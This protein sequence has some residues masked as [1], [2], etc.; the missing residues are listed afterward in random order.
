VESHYFAEHKNEWRS[1]V[2]T[3]VLLELER[4]TPDAISAEESAK[5]EV[6]WIP[7][8]KLLQMEMFNNNKTALE[9]A[10]GAYGAYTTPRY[11]ERQ[12]LVNSGSYSGLTVGEAIAKMTEAYGRKKTTYKLRDWIVSRQRYWGVPIPMIHCQMCGYQPV[13]DEQL[14]VLLPP[15]QD[16]LPDGSGKSP[17]AKVDAFVNTTCQTCGGKAERE[18]DTLDTFVDS[19]WYFLRYADP[20]NTGEFASRDKQDSWMPVDM[21]SGG[22]EHTTMHLLYSRFWHKALFDI[23]L[24]GDAEPYTSRVNHGMV[25]GPDGQKMSKSKGNVVDPDDMVERLGADTVRMYLA[26]MGPYTGGASYPWNPDSV[27]G[28]RRFIERVAKAQEYVQEQDV[29]ELNVPL[30]KALKKVGDD[31]VSFKFNTAISQLMIL[32]N[33]IER[34]KAIGKAQFEIVVHMIAPFAPHLAEELWHASGNESSIHRNAWPSYKAEH[35]QEDEITVAV[36]INGKKRGEARV[37][38]TA[39]KEETESAARTAV[40]DRLSEGEVVRVIIVP[41]RLVNFVMKI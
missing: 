27:V 12:E 30:H 35:L 5:H 29:A 2:D 32:L 13:P 31:I 10:L 4:D 41:G 24:V 11:G 18:T 22:A 26:F 37:A 16:Y 33:A 9:L 23:G 21:Y 39:T 38:S 1:R 28:V 36:Q 19:S 40:L 20:Q 15:V 6:Q 25:L 8:E 34:E 3:P 17:L 14:P 7:V